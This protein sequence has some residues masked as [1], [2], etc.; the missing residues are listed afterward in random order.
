MTPDWAL[1]LDWNLI[2][3]KA[4]KY[5]L[6]PELVAAVI[7]KESSGNTYALRYEPNYRWTFSVSDLAALIGCTNDTMEK[8]Q[9]TSFGLMQVMGGVAYEHGL[10]REENIYQRWASCL[11]IPEIGVE[12]GCR[13]IKRKSLGLSD[14]A[15]IYAAYNA[16]SVRKTAGGFYVNQLVVDGFM[17]LYRELKNV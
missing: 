7:Q 8:M 14:V 5:D 16:G 13:H 6:E 15:D 2:R 1:R 3:E 17:K 9:K 11:V 12:Y 4:S 10:H